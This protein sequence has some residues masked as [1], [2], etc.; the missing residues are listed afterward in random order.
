MGVG[1][2]LPVM[3]FEAV[4]LAVGEPELENPVDGLDEGV[5]VLVLVLAAEGDPEGVSVGVGVRE[6]DPRVGVPLAVCVAEVV[7]VSVREGEREGVELGE[8]GAK[9]AV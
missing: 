5:R 6:V 7:L 9:A 4:M 3:L 2:T 8:A 1:E